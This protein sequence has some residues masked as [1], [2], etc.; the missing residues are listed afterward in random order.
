MVCEPDR[1]HVCADKPCFQLCCP[2]WHVHQDGKCRSVRPSRFP[3]PPS[4]FVADFCSIRETT[5]PIAPPSLFV[6]VFG[7]EPRESDTLDDIRYFQHEDFEERCVAAGGGHVTTVPEG[8]AARLFEDGSLRVAEDN[9]TAD[10]IKFGHREFC[11]RNLASG[12][13]DFL[14]CHLPHDAT[15]AEEERRSLVQQMLIESETRSKVVVLQ[16]FLA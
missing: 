5:K 4:L 7:D 14:V 11:L 15:Q 12:E 8:P 2:E 9:A 16:L 13:K 1:S 6:Q 3:T 10:L